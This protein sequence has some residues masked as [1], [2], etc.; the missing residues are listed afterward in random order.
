MTAKSSSANDLYTLWLSHLGDERRLSKLTLRAYG[1]DVA[2]FI[3][4]L[5][6]HTG[7]APS[8]ATLK[9]LKA[10]DI[11]SWAALRRA[12]GLGPRGLARALA[13]VR[14]FFSFL[15]KSHGIENHDIALVRTPK[16]PH[17]L[18]KPIPAIDAA[19]TIEDAGN[20]REEAWEQARDTAL[21]T[22][23][24]GVGLRISEAL[25]LKQ[26]DAVLGDALRVTGK[27][28]KERIVPILPQVRDA[29]AAYA[30]LCPYQ[31]GPNELLFISTRGKPLSPRHAQLLMQHLRS[32]LGLAPSATPHALRHSFATH[33][34]SNGGDLRSIQELLGH[35]SLSTTQK[36]TEVDEARI[37]SVYE[38]AHPRARS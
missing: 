30:K 31:R 25:S 34:L 16:L 9:S 2:S 7:S 28:N 11:R 14:S 36:Y 37:L 22:L 6:I 32:R 26:S 33:L 3:G 23:L 13:A 38:N 21:V 17:S 10:A 24:Y 1:D 12:N 15:A 19:R 18:P 29:I 35:A 27:G 8:S 20:V 5:N 4:F